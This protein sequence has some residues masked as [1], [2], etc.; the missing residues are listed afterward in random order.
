M[1]TILWEI[2]KKAIPVLLAPVYKLI[3]SLGADFPLSEE[4]FY[5]LVLWALYQ[6]FKLAN[7][8]RKQDKN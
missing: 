1:F 2:L 6:L 3:L 5:A 7:I 8:A 4:L